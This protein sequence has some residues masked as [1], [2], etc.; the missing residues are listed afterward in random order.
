LKERKWREPF[1]RAQTLVD[2]DPVGAL[3]LM[4]LALGEYLSQKKGILKGSLLTRDLYDELIKRGVKE[5]QAKRVQSLAQTSENQRFLPPELA[6][7]PA[8]A[9]RA[10]EEF[11]AL[12]DGIS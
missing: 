8:A 7:D 11:K 1:A 2:Q 5:V 9:R 4:D 3:A 6:R 12:V 10:L